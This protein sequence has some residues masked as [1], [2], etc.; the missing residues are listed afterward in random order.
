M[1]EQT[2]PPLIIRSIKIIQEIEA[3]NRHPR[4]NQ[5]LHYLFALSSRISLTHFTS[6]FLC[7][8]SVQGNDA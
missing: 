5:R 6:V 4:G 3:K 2:I 8:V 7:F 1:I